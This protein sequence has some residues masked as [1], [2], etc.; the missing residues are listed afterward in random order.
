M[1]SNNEKCTNTQNK[2]TNTHRNVCMSIL[3]TCARTPWH[4]YALSLCVC[5]NWLLQFSRI[6]TECY[7]NVDQSYLPY[8]QILLK[9]D[10]EHRVW[11]DIHLH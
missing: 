2:H 9:E 1:K 6:P 7:R 4:T 10:I 3:F 11:E 5:T 8:I